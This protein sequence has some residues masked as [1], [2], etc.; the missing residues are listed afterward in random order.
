MSEFLIVK[1][2]IFPLVSIIGSILIL[3]FGLIFAKD[4]NVLYA[5]C[6]CFVLY[7]VFGYWKSSL[8]VLPI[9]IIFSAIFG[10]LTYVISKDLVETIASINRVLAITICV[11]PGL[12]LSPVVLTRSLKQLKLP[13]G[14]ILGLLITLTFFPLL[15]KEVSRVKEAM[16]TRG[17]NSLF[18]VKIFYRALL[19]PLVTRLVNISDTLSLSIET[20]GF[21]VLR[22][23]PVVMYKKVKFNLLDLTYLVI[24]ITG[25]V[26]AVCL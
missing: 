24:I 10:G 7:P 16:K 12:S 21:T 26:L 8:V 13:R 3:V 15:R 17:A 23:E 2:P 4:T 22:K 14:L 18:N 5:L 6:A 11:I 1:R 25:L 19:I 20:R 9:S